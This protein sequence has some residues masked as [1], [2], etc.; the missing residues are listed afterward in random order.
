MPLAIRSATRDD[1]PEVARIYVDSWTAGFGALLPPPTLDAAQIDRWAEELAAPG[2]ARWWVA[3]DAG[4]I[5][6]FVGV[7]PSRDPIEDGLGELDTIAVD[8]ACWRGGVGAAL[9]TTAVDALADAGYRRAILWTVD[10]YE[11]GRGFYESQG[12]RRDERLVRDDSRQI[13]FRRDL[14]PVA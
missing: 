2:P 7:G 1:A 5:A 13:A 10:R 6:G 8:P 3:D 9:M 12:W 14:P 4:R 11:Q